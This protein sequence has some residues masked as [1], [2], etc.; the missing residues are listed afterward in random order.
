MNYFKIGQIINTHGIKGE[1]K[2]YPYT[3]DVNKLSKKKKFYFDENLTE[4]IKVKSSK[5][6]KN[7]LIT[8]FE[9]VDTVEDAEKLKNKYIYVE[10]NEN[11]V[12]EEDTYYIQD[13]IGMQVVSEEAD[14]V[15]GVLEYV[16]NTGSNDVY[17]IK[18]VDN[19]NIYLPAIQD[20]VKS[21]DIKNK[22]MVV[23]IMEGL[24]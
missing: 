13:L 4:E 19:K 8:K 7:L 20:V 11:E 21:V 15:I 6:H 24:I 12:L 23:K 14:K 5:V 1:V 2:I 10:K 3:D 17:E 18:T 9:N 22:K 16:W